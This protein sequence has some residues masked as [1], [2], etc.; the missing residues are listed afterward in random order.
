MKNKRSAKSDH[1]IELVAEIYND[2]P[3]P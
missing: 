3:D 2:A 1:M